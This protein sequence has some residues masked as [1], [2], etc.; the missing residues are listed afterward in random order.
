MQTDQPFLHAMGARFE[1]SASGRFISPDP[2]GFLGS[3]INLQLY[4]NNN[5]NQFAD[6]SGLSAVSNAVD[7]LGLRL[8]G[9]TTD[10]SDGFDAGVDIFQA[11]LLE[12]RLEGRL[13]LLAGL[14]EYSLAS[15]LAS[16][17]V[18]I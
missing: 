7:E 8:L 15:S 3:G 18:V 9:Y 6:P 1:S 16:K 2:I 14:L 13:E 5:P 17:L 4:A 12:A 10:A 11:V